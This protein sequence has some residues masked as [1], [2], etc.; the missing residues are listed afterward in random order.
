[1]NLTGPHQFTRTFHNIEKDKRPLLVSHKDV[2]WLFYS[3]YG[4]FIS[5]FKGVKH[6]SSLKNLRTINSKKNT[7]LHEK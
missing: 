5:P 2:D 7:I 6:Y 1:M 3:K 4:D